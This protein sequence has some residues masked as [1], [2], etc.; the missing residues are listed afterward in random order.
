MIVIDIEEYLNKKPVASA[1]EIYKEAYKERLRKRLRER[2][3]REER[4]KKVILFS[5]ND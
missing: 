3:K 1:R 5:K 4:A 2:I